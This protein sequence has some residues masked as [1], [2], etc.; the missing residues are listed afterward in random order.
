MK[1]NQ[2]VVFPEKTMTTALE[3]L[4]EGSLHLDVRDKVVT[5][6]GVSTVHM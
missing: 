1:H 4:A 5:A 6:T 3:E 2:S